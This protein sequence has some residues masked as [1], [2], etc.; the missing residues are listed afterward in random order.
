MDNSSFRAINNERQAQREN[1]EP[2]LELMVDKMSI[3]EDDAM[4]AGEAME[5]EKMMEPKE[6]PFM[7]S[8]PQEVS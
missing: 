7:D 8:K 3:D 1:S 4:K 5:S 2:S 6:E